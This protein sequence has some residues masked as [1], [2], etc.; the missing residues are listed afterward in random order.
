MHYCYRR[1]N[2]S[3][4]CVTLRRAAFSAAI[5]ANS[6]SFAS[7]CSCACCSIRFLSSSLNVLLDLSSAIVK[8]AG[9]CPAAALR[10]CQMAKPV[11]LRTSGGGDWY[12]CSSICN[13]SS[14]A[15]DAFSASAASLRPR[16]AAA[17]ISSLLNA[18]PPPAGTAAA[19][20]RAG[21][22]VVVVYLYLYLYLYLA[23]LL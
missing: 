3:L 9:S 13:C 11:G 10:A 17:S 1:L 16:P 21:W 19:R 20:A 22:R 14:V 12:S 6:F 4:I 8:V 15:P 2:S 18:P 7:F 23:P 5:F